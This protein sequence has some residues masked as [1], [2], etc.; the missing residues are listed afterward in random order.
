MGALNSMG[1]KIRGMVDPKWKQRKE[2]QMEKFAQQASGFGNDVSRTKDSEHNV[3]STAS[4]EDNHFG[5]NRNYITNDFNKDG[6]FDMTRNHYRVD[7]DKLVGRINYHYGD[8]G[9]TLSYDDIRDMKNKYREN[10]N[11]YNNEELQNKDEELSK[12]RSS[13]SRLNT[14]FQIGQNARKNNSYQMYDKENR[15]WDDVQN[16]TGIKSQAFKRLR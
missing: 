3:T 6:G 10:E 1:G 8:D 7:P 13:N 16:G 12:I 2:R 9:Q 11:F 4:L 15:K 5:D 14:A